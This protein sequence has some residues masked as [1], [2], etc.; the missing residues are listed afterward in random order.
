MNI[1]QLSDGCCRSA[2]RLLISRTRPE[3]LQQSLVIHILKSQGL[4]LCR[5][6]RRSP[7]ASVDIVGAGTGATQQNANRCLE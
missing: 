1:Q 2:E 3:I 6:N 4:R 7:G 5:R